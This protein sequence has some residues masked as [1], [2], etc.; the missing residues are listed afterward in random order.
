M[1]ILTLAFY[2][3]YIKNQS[4]NPISTY[5]RAYMPFF[6]NVQTLMPVP[7]IP[8]ETTQHHSS[9]YVSC[10]CRESPYAAHT[11]I[12][13]FFADAIRAFRPFF[14]LSSWCVCLLFFP[15]FLLFFPPFLMLLVWCISF[16]SGLPH[17]NSEKSPIKVRQIQIQIWTLVRFQNPSLRSPSPERSHITVI[18]PSRPCTT[19]ITFRIWLEGM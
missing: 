12:I 18:S 3:M 15:P 6:S 2:S 19:W 17:K 4:T 10:A 8:M 5:P 16:S 13:S 7:D 11:L 1:M 14:F 9:V